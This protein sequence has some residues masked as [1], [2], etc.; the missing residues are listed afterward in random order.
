MRSPAPLGPLRLAGGERLGS[1]TGGPQFRRTE[2]SE[3]MRINSAIRTGRLNRRS[4]FILLILAFVL[5]TVIVLA[6]SC[7]LST[8]LPPF[9]DPSS[10]F[11]V[12]LVN[13]TGGNII[14]QER[15]R[16]GEGCTYKP[17][18]YDSRH[19]VGGPLLPGER[20]SL[21][22]AIGNTY[23]YRLV[24]SAGRPFGCIVL[25]SPPVREGQALRASDASP[26]RESTGP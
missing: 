12:P 10:L 5:V 2:S 15:C 1:P 14:V 24:D 17:Y 3:I 22:A 18:V 23:D 19:P 6:V 9:P 26:C 16:Q 20:S 7:S 11:W 13:D 21:A 4:R 25:R 8:L